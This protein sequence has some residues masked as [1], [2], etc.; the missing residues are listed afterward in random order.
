V[1]AFERRR[2]GRGL[3]RGGARYGRHGGHHGGR[4][5]GLLRGDGRVRGRRDAGLAAAQLLPRDRAIARRAKEG[6]RVERRHRGRALATTANLGDTARARSTSTAW[7]TAPRGAGAEARRRLGAG[8][9]SVDELT[10]QVDADAV[11]LDAALALGRLGTRLGEVE[12]ESAARERELVAVV[13]RVNKV[14]RLV[15]GLAADGSVALGALQVE[16]EEQR[17][18]ARL[19]RAVRAVLGRTL[20][21]EVV[22]EHLLALA[23]LLGDARFERVVGSE[24]ADARVALHLDEAARDDAPGGVEV[25][26]PEVRALEAD[27]VAQLVGSLL[28]HAVQLEMRVERD[29]DLVLE[30]ALVFQVEA[31]EGQA[32]GFRPLRR[33]RDELQREP[34]GQRPE[35]VE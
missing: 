10:N 8:R 3:R 5:H 23:D 12:D 7:S 20:R 16:L 22:R 9:G 4:G 28:Q 6:G 21:I 1:A 25:E 32:Q 13:E 2:D 26:E 24:V 34:A 35:L 29:D 15:G 30:D 14:A 31:R 18:L 11:V 17:K 27:L 33:R 19:E